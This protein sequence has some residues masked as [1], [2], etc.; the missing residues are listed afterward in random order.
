MRGRSISDCFFILQDSGDSLQ[1]NG[2]VEETFSINDS[3]KRN[4]VYALGASIVLC[5]GVY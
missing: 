2:R 3:I 1:G 5:E 4:N